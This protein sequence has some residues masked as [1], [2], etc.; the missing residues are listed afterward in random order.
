MDSGL[1]SAHLASVSAGLSL[2]SAETDLI[3]AQL[4][5]VSVHSGLVSP[6]SHPISATFGLHFT[7]F[8][9]VCAQ[10]TAGSTDLDACGA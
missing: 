9:A 4:S 2:V 3:S 8:D 6:S 5:L 10:A 7:A 1:V